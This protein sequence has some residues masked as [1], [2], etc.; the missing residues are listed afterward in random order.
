MCL[1]DLHNREEKVLNFLK[2]I[3]DEKVREILGGML[4]F[5]PSKRFGYHDVLERIQQL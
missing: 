3:K 5:D 2:S 4:E 1:N